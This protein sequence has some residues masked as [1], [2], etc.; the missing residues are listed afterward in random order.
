MTYM[1]TERLRLRNL[2]PSDLDALYS[3]RNNEICA[4]FQRWEDTSREFLAGYIQKFGADVFG[5]NAQEQHYAVAEKDGTLAGDLSCF[6]TEADN[7]ITLGITISHQRQ[8]RGYAFEILSAAVTQ[9]KVR[10]PA[11]D[12]VALIEK[13]NTASIA[14]FEKLGFQ[15]ECYAKSIGSYVYTIFGKK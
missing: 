4:R 9:L 15:Q 5:S 3:Y 2:E 6:F 1:E 8:H 12:I 14:L 11:M 7:C 10:Y 13:E